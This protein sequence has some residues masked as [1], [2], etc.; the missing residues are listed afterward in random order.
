M[1]SIFLLMLLF[2]ILT[3]RTVDDYFYSCSIYC[4]PSTSL[5][6][7]IDLTYSQALTWNNRVLGIFFSSLFVIIAFFVAL[8]YLRDVVIF[9]L[10]ISDG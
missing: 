6:D 10:H 4:V 1:I 9:Y 5:K 2:N 8:V 7:V 3:L